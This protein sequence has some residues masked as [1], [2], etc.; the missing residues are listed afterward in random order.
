MLVFRSG[1][2]NSYNHAYPTN[3]APEYISR[4]KVVESAHADLEVAEPKWDENGR[5][6]TA[7]VHPSHIAGCRSLSFLV[8]YPNRVHRSSCEKITLACAGTNHDEVSTAG[9]R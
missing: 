7:G 8:R 5:I 2:M 3:L 1:V 6:F 4:H 9:A